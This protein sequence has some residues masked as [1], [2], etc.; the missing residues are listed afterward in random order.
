[1]V[2]IQASSAVAFFL[3]TIEHAF[4]ETL[5]EPSEYGF[6]IGIIS[7]EPSDDGSYTCI[8]MLLPLFVAISD[9][10]FGGGDIGCYLLGG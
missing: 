4:A 7:G 5:L 9:C 3:V 8:C 2:I 10:S 6:I 1:M